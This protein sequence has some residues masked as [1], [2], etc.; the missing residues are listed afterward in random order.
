MV[1][2]KDA[3]GMYEIKFDSVRRICYEKNAGFWHK[4]DIERFHDDYVKKVSH[5]F[6]GQPWAICCDLR[7]Y[8]TSNISEEMEKHVQWKL[9]LGMS[10]AAVIVSDPI[11]KMQ[12]NRASGGKY[13][14]MAFTSEQEADE[15]LKSKGF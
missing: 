10:C 5:V 4:E 9:S 15:W 11:V 8:K 3:K 13:P 14:Q 12:L 1:Q 2:V 6:S 7:E